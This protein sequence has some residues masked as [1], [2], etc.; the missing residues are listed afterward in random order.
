MAELN[1]ALIGLLGVMTGGYFN[2]FLAEDYKRF[3]DAQALAGALAGELESHG[4]P[5][6]VIVDGLESMWLKLADGKKLDLPE[7]PIPASPLFDQNASKIGLLGAELAREVAYVYENL[8]AFRQNFHVLS[9]HHST[10]PSEWAQATIVGC[11]AAITRAE[12][13]GMPLVDNLKS[14][15]AESYWSRPQTR[16]QLKYGAAAIAVLLVVLKMLS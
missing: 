8:R 9:K 4:M 12:A 2:N 3:R 6:K 7:W 14:F 15:A 11:Q 10:M 5:V 13:R 1:V 16:T